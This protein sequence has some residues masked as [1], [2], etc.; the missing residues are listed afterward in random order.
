MILK[1]FLGISMLV[2]GTFLICSELKLESIISIVDS[3]LAVSILA[4]GYGE[5]ALHGISAIYLLGLDI[6]WSTGLQG[7]VDM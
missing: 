4:K 7:K 3:T 6:Q 5:K 2:N 1:V